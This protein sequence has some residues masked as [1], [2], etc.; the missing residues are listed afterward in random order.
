MSIPK[1]L[2]STPHPTPPSY[3]PNPTHL[4]PF[5]FFPPPLSLPVPSAVPASLANLTASLS[6]T[7]RFG[8]GAGAGQ[9]FPAT[10]S[11]VPSSSPPCP[12]SFTRV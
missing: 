7:S 10:F 5:L 1:P 2:Q 4:Y 6:P 3:Q 8:A 11:S 9:G 12:N